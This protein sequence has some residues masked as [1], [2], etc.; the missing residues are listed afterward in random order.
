MGKREKRIKKEIES[1]E[2]QIQ[3]HVNKLRTE[4]GLK[5][6]TPGY[7]KKEIELKFK[8]RIEDRIK[9]LNRKKK[10]YSISG[11]RQ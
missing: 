5:D 10:F 2:K 9:K 1:L 11:K 7:W 8:K 6:T 4:I 3:K